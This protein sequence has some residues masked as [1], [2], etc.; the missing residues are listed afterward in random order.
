MTAKIFVFGTGRSGTH[1]VVDILG[2][3]EK[4]V[5]LH[6]GRGTGPAGE[7][8]DLGNLMGV[9]VLLAGGR[10]RLRYYRES[11]VPE[12]FP[13]A[14]MERAFRSRHDLISRCVREGFHY[15]DINRLGYNC[16]NYIRQEYPEAK[17]VHVVRDGYRCVRSWYG[18]I[19]AYPGRDELLRFKGGQLR[20]RYLQRKKGGQGL[21]DLAYDLYVAALLRRGSESAGAEK[22]LAAL[23][24]RNQHLEKPRPL[25]GDPHHPAWGSYSRLQKLA[26]FWSWVNES[27]ERRLE[28]V[29]EGQRLTLR[30]EDLDTA[31]AGRLADFCGLRGGKFESRRVVRGRSREY[32]VEWDDGSRRQFNEIAGEG[33]KKYGY[34][35]VGPTRDA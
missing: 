3:R 6:E 33:M 10:D 2:S 1:S 24:G 26:W 12:G 4:T 20:R 21:A 14:I 28:S 31:F 35:L 9:N 22:A 27:I 11:L 25:P 17:F 18:R 13:L 30:I 7:R 8:V 23:S 15:C 19:G 34:D 5:S 29:P 16:I 32:A